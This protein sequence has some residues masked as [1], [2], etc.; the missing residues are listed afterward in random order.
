MKSNNKGSVRFKKIKWVGGEYYRLIG[1]DSPLSKDQVRKDLG[2]LLSEYLVISGD[3]S[4]NTEAAF[5]KLRR[6]IQKEGYEIILL[7]ESNG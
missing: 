7:G 6:D 1:V 4:V 5:A 2:I 3:I